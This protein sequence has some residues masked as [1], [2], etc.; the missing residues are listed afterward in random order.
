MDAVLL[1]PVSEALEFEGHSVDSHLAHILLGGGPCMVNCGYRK[2]SPEEAIDTKWLA[3]RYYAPSDDLNQPVDKAAAGQFVVLVEKVIERV[4]D[5][6]TKPGWKPESIFG[7]NAQQMREIARAGHSGPAN[8]E[9]VR[10]MAPAAGR[11]ARRCGAKEPTERAPGRLGL[12]GSRAPRLG[13]SR[14]TRGE[15]AQ[16]DPATNRIFANF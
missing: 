5:A 7:R 13:K 4:A 11:I 8:A 6:D 2:G 3:E 15:A 12:D 16:N 14:R 10:C 9:Y 1:R